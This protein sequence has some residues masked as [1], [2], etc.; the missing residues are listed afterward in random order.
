MD[1]Q[2]NLNTKK[3]GPDTPKTGH[4]RPQPGQHRPQPPGLAP[5]A[6]QKAATAATTLGDN[7]RESA[8]SPPF[9][10]PFYTSVLGRDRPSRTLSHRRYI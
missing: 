1:A 4:Q 9:K 2:H 7:H 3:R 8:S 5:H 10:S 6:Q